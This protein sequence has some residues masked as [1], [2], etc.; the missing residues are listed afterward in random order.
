MQHITEITG[1]YLVFTSLEDF[2]F[3]ANSVRFKNIF[4]EKTT[5]VI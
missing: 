4:L 2:V 1:Y 5:S 3:E